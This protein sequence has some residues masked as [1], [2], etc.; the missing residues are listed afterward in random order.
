MSAATD[1]AAANRP[2]LQKLL[3]V[4]AGMF[5][6]GFAM[7]PFY[8]QICEVDGHPQHR[9]PDAVR[10]TRR[11]TRRARSRSSSTRNLRRP[12]VAVQ[13]DEAQRAASIRASCAGRV[14]KSSTRLGRPSPARRSRATR[15]STPRSTSRSSTASASRQQTLQPGECA[16]DAGRVRH[17][18]D[19][20]D[21]RARRSRCRTRSSRSKAPAKVA[22]RRRRSA[23]PKPRSPNERHHAGAPRPRITSRSRRT[24]RSSA[25]SRCS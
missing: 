16:R 21:G 20:A 11:S 18:S 10:R 9:A 14:S 25:R 24:G 6:F 8:E 12:A 5:G 7:V 15:R 13:A 1:L 17:R 4:A 2:L 19:A 23:R 22:P 3:V